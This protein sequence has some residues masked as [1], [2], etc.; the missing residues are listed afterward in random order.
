MKSCDSFFFARGP[1]FTSIVA[2]GIYCAG[3]CFWHVCM[4][5]NIGSGLTEDEYGRFRARTHFSS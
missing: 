4:R 2:R 1:L 3:M 5:V